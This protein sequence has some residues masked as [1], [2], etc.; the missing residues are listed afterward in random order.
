MER[1]GAERQAQQDY[2]FFDQPKKATHTWSAALKAEIETRFPRQYVLMQNINTPEET[3]PRR[4]FL[5][6]RFSAERMGAVGLKGEVGKCLCVGPYKGSIEHGIRA[7]LSSISFDRPPLRRTSV[8]GRGDI[9]QHPH[10]IGK[11]K[12]TYHGGRFVYKAATTRQ[13]GNL[14]RFTYKRLR[15]SYRTQ[16]GGLINKEK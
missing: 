14:N 4:S 6:M 12:I 11:L 9:L 15:K 1:S 2:W 5:E 13:T 7:S 3:I 10:N 8:Q 16:V